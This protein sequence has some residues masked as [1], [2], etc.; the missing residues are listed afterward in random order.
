MLDFAY[1]G[2]LGQILRRKDN[3]EAAFSVVFRDPKESE[4]LIGRLAGFRQETMHFRPLSDHEFLYL[5]VACQWIVQCLDHAVD[6]SNG[7]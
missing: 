5:T 6:G 1:I 4:V 3:W 7:R 2:D